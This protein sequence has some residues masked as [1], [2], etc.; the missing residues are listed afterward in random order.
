MAKRNLN[1]LMIVLVA[2][3]VLSLGYIAYDKYSSWKQ[4]RDLSNFQLGVQYGFEQ[5]ITQLVQQ[6]QT[7]EQVP[8]LYNNQTI[9]M[10]AVECLQQQG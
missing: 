6:A 3:L 9:N 10:I 1:I 7:C 2:L 8:I 5:A 4:N